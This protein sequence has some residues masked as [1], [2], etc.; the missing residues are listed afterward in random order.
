MEARLKKW[1][2]RLTLPLRFCKLLGTVTKTCWKHRKVV[3]V[4]LRMMID[5]KPAHY[6]ERRFCEQYM[7]MPKNKPILAKYSDGRAGEAQ[8][9]SGI[10]RFNEYG[11]KF[12]GVNDTIKDRMVQPALMLMDEIFGNLKNTKIEK[13]SI[14][15]LLRPM[16]IAFNKAQL[17]YF[18]QYLSRA[19]Y[20]DKSDAWVRKKM[21]SDATTQIYR[22]LYEWGLTITKMDGS[23][24]AFLETFL[25]MLYCELNEE[26]KDKKH[27]HHMYYSGAD[28]ND[29]LFF[30]MQKKVVTRE[31]P[32]LE[33]LHANINPL[34]IKKNKR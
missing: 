32:E 18:R 16:D 4:A 26:F 2:L 34:W 9:L 13:G 3:K 31:I 24:R 20:N 6:H 14:N 10:N 28:S 11:R 19:E 21:K 30:R 27:P 22:S 8:T 5:G 25:I 33:A 15:Y 17:V 1:Y 29:P 12:H 23:V 7:N